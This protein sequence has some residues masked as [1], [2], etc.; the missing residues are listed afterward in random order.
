[1]IVDAVS[2][3]FNLL[4]SFSF[5]PLHYSAHDYYGMVY[6]YYSLTVLQFYDFFLKV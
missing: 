5:S 2:T 6:D 4:V 3:Q 1:M